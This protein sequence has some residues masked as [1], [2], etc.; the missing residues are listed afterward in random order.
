MPGSLKAAN[1]RRPLGRLAEHS[2]KHRKATARLDETST[3]RRRDVVKDLVERIRSDHL[4]EDWPTREDTAYVPRLVGDPG[5][6]EAVLLS[7]PGTR[8]EPG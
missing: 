5:N 7:Q 2:G 6:E 1:S 4:D 8:M 3:V